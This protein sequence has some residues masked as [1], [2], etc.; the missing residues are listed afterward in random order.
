MSKNGRHPQTFPAV[1]LGDESLTEDYLPTR[2]MNSRSLAVTEET[3][4]VKLSR[5]L[6]SALQLA[7]EGEQAVRAFGLWDDETGINVLV[8]AL[9]MAPSLYPFKKLRCVAKLLHE[10]A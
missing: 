6:V 1:L 3:S 9:A 10:I 7:P 8:K 4:A 2:V 5:D